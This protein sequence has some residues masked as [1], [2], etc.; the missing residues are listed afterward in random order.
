MPLSFLPE[1][2]NALAGD[3]LFRTVAAGCAVKRVG[4]VW[5]ET[6]MQ[7]DDQGLDVVNPWSAVVQ[8]FELRTF[9]VNFNTS[10]WTGRK[11]VRMSAIPTADMRTSV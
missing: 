3:R 5:P 11:S 1:H 8:N 10:I 4:A 2:D 7:F 6:V 9:N